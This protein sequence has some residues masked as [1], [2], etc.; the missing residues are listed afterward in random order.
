MRVGT[1][2]SLLT[3][4]KRKKKKPGREKEKN[5]KSGGAFKDAVI[6][7]KLDAN[8]ADNGWRYSDDRRKEE[9]RKRVTSKTN[10]R[11]GERGFYNKED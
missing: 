5:A 11:G 8:G 10:K 9:K 3:R 4:T 7:V 1:T 6:Q 2:I